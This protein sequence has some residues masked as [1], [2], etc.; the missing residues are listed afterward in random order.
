MDYIS[1]TYFVSPWSLEVEGSNT[2]TA[3][4]SYHNFNGIGQLEAWRR[5][6]EGTAGQE[7]FRNKELDPT[8]GDF[9]TMEWRRTN[10]ASGVTLVGAGTVSQQQNA[11]YGIIL[12][13]KRKKDGRYITRSYP[14]A[15]DGITLENASS[16][17]TLPSGFDYTSDAGPGIKNTTL[18]TTNASRGSV[19]Q[20]SKMPSY[21]DMTPVAES[22]AGVVATTIQLA[23]RALN[24]LRQ[25]DDVRTYYTVT[26]VLHKNVKPGQT[27]DVTY[28]L[29]GENG[30]SISETG[31]YIQS[32][33]YSLNR[34]GTR[35]VTLSLSST[36]WPYSGDRDF[37]D[38]QNRAIEGLARLKPR[39]GGAI[40]G[41]VLIV[42]PPVDTS[43]F[44]SKNGGNLTGNVTADAGV[45]IDGRDVSVDGAT[46]DAI[47]S[48]YVP[49]TRTISTSSPLT[50][51]GDLSAN[52][53][54]SFSSQTA[55]H[56]LL[57]PDGSNG[58]PSFR[59]LVSD[60]LP[61]HDIISKH[62][63]SGGANLDV[64]GL[65]A[66]STI[67]RLTP[68]ASPG[69]AAAILRTDS[70][71]VVSPAQ[72]HLNPVGNIYSSLRIGPAP[73]SSQH[74]TNIIHEQPGTRMEVRRSGGGGF[75]TSLFDVAGST[76]TGDITALGAFGILGTLP[77]TATYLYLG[78]RDGADP[79][80]TNPQ[81]MIR[82]GGIRVRAQVAGDDAAIF[83][84]RSSTGIGVR[85]IGAASQT[86]NM[87]EA[88]DSGTSPVFKVD[89]A[90]RVS[91]RAIRPVFD[92]VSNLAIESAAGSTMLTVNTTADTLLLS[93]ST[94]ISGD[95]WT[96]GFLGNQ[97]GIDTSAGHADFRSIYADELRVTTFIAEGAFVRA[98][99]QYITP[100]MAQLSRDF[101]IPSTGS[102]T[103]YVEDIEGSADTAVFTENEYV[104]IRIVDRSGGGLVVGNAWGVVTS[105][106]DLSGG[107]QSWSFTAVS[108]DSGVGGQ[109]ATA[110]AVAL[111]FGKS[112]DGY[113]VSTTLDQAGSPY[114]R[115]TTWT[116]N[117]YTASNR[118]VHAQWG[119]LDGLA[120]I[121][122]EFGFYAGLSPSSA[123][124]IASDTQVALHS[125]PLS[126]YAG[127]ENDICYLFTLRLNTD[128][129]TGRKTNG[130][131]SSSN[132]SYSTGSS[133]S[134]I[135]A[136]TT[137][138]WTYNTGNSKNANAWLDLESI[139][140]GMDYLEIEANGYVTSTNDG[141]VL[142]AQIFKSDGTTELTDE[143][144]LLNQDYTTYTT[145]TKRFGY[146]DDSASQTDWDGARLRLQWYYY[147]ASS[148]SEVIRLDPFAPS[149][150]VGSPLPT[151][152][153]TGDGMWAGLA[154]DGYYKWKVGKATAQQIRWDGLN[155]RL[156]DA[157][158]N[159]TIIFQSTGNARFDGVI[160]V[161]TSGGIW[162]GT[163]TFASPT[164]GLKIWN[165]GGVGRI[166]GYG[167][168]TL[169]AGF[170]TSGQ[171]TAGAGNVILD[172]DGVTLDAV[173][174]KFTTGS[175]DWKDGSSTKLSVGTVV[176]LGN[177]TGTYI[178]S[179]DSALEIKTTTSG[180]ITLSADDGDGFVIIDGAIEPRTI[181]TP[182]APANSISRIYQR[183]TKLIVQ[184]GDSGTTRYKY[185]ELSGTGATW[186][187]TTTAP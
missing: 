167:S 156:M 16:Y 124:I 51:G 126:L 172:E 34:H 127:G 88:Q 175:I 18:E 63:Y 110:G 85:V 106:T 60:D 184:Y 3:D 61:A 138:D 70:S 56:A 158:G 105:Y 149:I 17:Y 140:T 159:N 171:L 89:S 53:T 33:K 104:L 133:A 8:S 182:S 125:V 57:A 64:F 179:L 38:R 114:E 164:T 42:N 122:R 144:M 94:D 35:V 19:H 113:I 7:W 93:T 112:G 46:L 65:S 83:T 47:P 22:T 52:R 90:G 163:G 136:G 25:N 128:L 80:Y 165:D 48:A 145:Y 155:L 101:V 54:I 143:L 23:K 162:Q 187:H 55:N 99:S 5:I 107:E 154:S 50:G 84:P 28:T 2:G 117:P 103:L 40:S 160:E 74:T 102:A 4:G 185:L 78:V 146:V 58:T 11:S 111:G 153:D 119:N 30:E 49:Q 142:T 97:W 32:V 45:T 120:G 75:F 10:D 76:G 59:A 135:L 43:D 87:I 137:S 37:R 147:P 152:F 86:A 169:Q 180:S 148:N 36:A 68:L 73:L 9:R 170:N 14:I 109:T 178:E 173:V 129:Q 150:A 151:S 116:G 15:G 123:R 81:F 118:K 69:N 39:D 41:D 161:G 21:P 31:L 132:I 6:A 134:A 100:S 131:I 72:V 77:D 92:G 186:T 26:C 62:S 13:L 95:T 44:L 183:G 1:T 71:G 166:A 91:T 98:G 141:I 177:V 67:A 82:P 108:I 174:G 66:A 96:S 139:T 79:A 181:N 24:L 27:I 121:D 157:A 130:D 12:D 20:V 176:D 29:P 168:G 115:I